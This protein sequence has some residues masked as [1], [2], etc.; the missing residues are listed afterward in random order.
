LSRSLTAKPNRNGSPNAKA[1]Q[2]DVSP[3]LV[4]RVHK[5]YEQLG[6]EDVRAVQELA[7]RIK[8][9]INSKDFRV[10]PGEKVKLIEWP[11]T[12]KAL[13]Q[14]EEAVSRTLEKHVE[15]L[16]ALQHLH[17]ASTAMRCC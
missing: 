11:T 2:S 14:V 4:N 16:S 1:S 8:M 6:R 12:G 15:E 9:K 13:L 3:Q 10:R 7:E 17:Y 5:L